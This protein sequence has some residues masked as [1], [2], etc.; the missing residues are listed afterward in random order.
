VN[1]RTIGD[2][3][4]A[5]DPLAG[6]GIANALKSGIEA[7][8]EIHRELQWGG[9]H[10]GADIGSQSVNSI[11]RQFTEYLEQR[12]RYYGMEQRWSD[13]LFW[14]RR[15]P[16]DFPRIEIV[17]DPET[18]LLAPL[19]V[20]S[21]AALAPIEALLPPRAIR[22]FLRHL[23]TPMIAHAALAS[24]RHLT[25]PIGDLRLLTAT[26]LMLNAGIIHVVGAD[27]ADAQF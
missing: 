13:S 19:E 20:P 11:P 24:L 15:H 27:S 9:E 23:Q 14:A 3:A 21:T 10:A 7:S 8:Q 25:G 4:V 16:I 6:T 22:D 12:A 5:R 17:L 26:Q 18:V 2:A 1:W